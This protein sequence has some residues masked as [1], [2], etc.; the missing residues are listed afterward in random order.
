MIQ[1]CAENRHS[2]RIWF[3]ETEQSKDLTSVQTVF[4]YKL[5]AIHHSNKQWI[6]VVLLALNVQIKNVLKHEQNCVYRI[7]LHLAY[8]L[9]LLWVTSKSCN[10]LSLSINYS[11]IIWVANNYNMRTEPRFLNRTE[12]NSF[13]TKSEFFFKT[14]Q[15][16][17]ECLKNL[18]RTFLVTAY[19]GFVHGRAD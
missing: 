13:R 15:N 3:L 1:R 5:H 8:L 14:E 2:V 6:E 18:F 12:Q 9:S 19:V 4:R 16:W 7:Q 11:A 10:P 17:T